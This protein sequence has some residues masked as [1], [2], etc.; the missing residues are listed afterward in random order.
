MRECWFDLLIFFALRESRGLKCHGHVSRSTSI[1]AGSCYLAEHR[2][3]R[4]LQLR[5]SFEALDPGI[6]GD[7]V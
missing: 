3:E 5:A 1:V 6:G 2:V 7:V 4:V